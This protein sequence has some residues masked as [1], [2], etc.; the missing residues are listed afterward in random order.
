[1]AYEYDNAGR[2]TLETDALSKTVQSYYDQNG[3][4]TRQVDKCGKTTDYACDALARRT[5][6]TDPA[7]E[8]VALYYDTLGRLTS[9]DRGDLNANK[10]GLDGDLL[11]HFQPRRHTQPRARNGNL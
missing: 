10:N 5:L 1:M 8:K 6:V 7:G 4:L 2:V 3:N 11:F 9:A